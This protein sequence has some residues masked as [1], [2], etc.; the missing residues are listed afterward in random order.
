MSTHDAI[1]ERSLVSRSAGLLSRFRKDERGNI[2]IVAGLVLPVVV[3]A[4]GVAM[5]YSSASSSRAS[6]QMAV[7]AAVLA[8]AGLPDGASATDK[9]AAAQKIFQHNVKS[10]AQSSVRG[11]AATFSVDGD[12]VSGTATGSAV[13]PFG[14]I[15][16]S[17][18][19]S[20][21]VKAAARKNEA[22]V[23]VLGLN[24]FDRGSF[25]INGNPVFDAA[26]AVQANSTNSSGMTQEGRAP[27]KAKKFGVSGGHKTNN[28]D[29]VP[30][31][32]STRIADPYASLPFPTVGHCDKNASIL[33]ITDDTT[34]TPGTYCGGVHV[35]AGARV[36]LQPGVYVMSD[37]PFWATGNSTVTGDKVMIG[38]TGKDSSLY[39]WGNTS[40]SLT[41][42]TSGPY[43]N[44]Q[45][46]SDRN[47]SATNH[48][49]V[50]VGGN[51]FG[52]TGAPK[53]QYDGVAYFP[54]QNFWV[55]GNAR[56][57]ANS[58]SMVIVADKIWVQGRATTKITN[59]NPRNLNVKTIM[60]SYSVTLIR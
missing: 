9:V 14:G 31:E 33:K 29:P 46:M 37:G 44:M 20:L 57:E 7:D 2:A 48:L 55:F 34:L 27:V 38:F 6:M 12:V 60:T 22:R 58:P 8:G 26:C 45:F 36:T 42:P 54:K 17:Q 18:S 16:G 19:F 50:S 3:G 24:G 35:S 59:D 32:R 13:N 4:A 47:S 1:G 49:W 56:I 53:L 41:S 25:D 21:S 43:T 40:V 5:T 15:V 52:F 23:C 30:E 11:I 39:V 10:F 51:D 28:F